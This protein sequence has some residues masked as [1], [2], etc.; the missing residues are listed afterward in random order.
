MST[1]DTNA[2]SPLQAPDAAPYRLAIDS[3][4]VWTYNGAPLIHPKGLALFK[5]HLHRRGDGTYYVQFGPQEGPVEVADLPY[6]AS[7]KDVADAG[8]LVQWNT[9]P[10]ERITPD[11]LFQT[12]DGT[13]G[14]WVR[15]GQMPAKF[16]RQ[17]SMMLADYLDEHAKGVFWYSGPGGHWEIPLVRL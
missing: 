8:L 9:P 7:L 10:G 17:S 11:H 4:G 1:V 2:A 5:D 3:D 6:V 12:A 15:R 13:L 14:I 16:D